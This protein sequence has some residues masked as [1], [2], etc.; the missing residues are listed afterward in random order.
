MGLDRGIENYLPH[1]NSTVIDCD[2]TKLVAP[3]HTLHDATLQPQRAIGTHILQAV[4]VWSGRDKLVTKLQQ[5]FFVTVETVSAS[6]VRPKVL[7]LTGQGGIGKTSL[8]AKLLEAVGVDLASASVAPTCFYDRIICLKAED[9][10][11]FDE[12]AEFLMEALEVL[13]LQPLK[14]D[15]QKI[16]RIGQGL[17][18]CQNLILIDELE[19]WLHPPLDSNAGRTKIPSLGKLLHFLAYNNHQSQT[20]ITS[21][22]I[23]ADLANSHHEN[24]EPDP[25]LVWIETLGGVSIN[26]GIDILHQRQLEDCEEHLHWV[27]K[28]VDGH[29]FLLT[30]LASIAKGKP[31]YLWNHPE[32]VTQRAKPILKEQLARQSDAALALLKR[33][34]ILR[35]GI[36]TRGLTFLRLYTDVW[37]SDESASEPSSP[38]FTE[39]ALKAT[40][41][42]LNRLVDC[43]LVEYRYDERQAELFYDL[44]RVI[45]EFLQS[46]YHEELPNLLKNVYSFYRA[47]KDIGYPKKL[48]DLRPALEAYFFAYQTSDIREAYNLL[49]GKLH[50]HLKRLGHWTSLYSMCEQV[51]P[52]AEE[53]EKSSCLMLLGDICIEFGDLDQAEQHFQNALPIVQAQENENEIELCNLQLQLISNIREEDILDEMIFDSKIEYKILYP[54]SSFPDFLADYRQKSAASTANMHRKNLEYKSERYRA[55]VAEHGESELADA[56]FLPQIGETA[57][58]LG[59]SELNAGNFEVAREVLQQALQIVDEWGM[60]KYIALANYHLA[61]LERSLQNTDLAETYFSTAYDIFL[62]LGATR[63]LMRIQRVWQQMDD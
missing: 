32:L 15:G 30:Q 26:A 24:S 48:N 40:Q 59:A 14:S 60:I 39:A 20:I 36:D 43:C 55:F 54:T 45:K 49:K 17:Q 52:F 9:S 5:Q 62:N 50:D 61:R 57:V 44:H 19:A 18:R 33:M 11:S 41:A 8:A 35:V 23:P 53:N 4:P 58:K 31:G 12:V 37:L 47:S 42:I 34:S 28:R 6:V 25:T 51:L 46:E 38:V 29:V 3:T 27:A 13:P 7:V 22:E 21:R 1:K 10:S 56:T 2:R 16:S 63:E